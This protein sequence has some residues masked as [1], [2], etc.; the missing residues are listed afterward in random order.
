MCHVGRTTSNKQRVQAV[1][2]DVISYEHRGYTSNYRQYL[3]SL[4]KPIMHLPTNSAFRFSLSSLP[5]PSEDHNSM[6][7]MNPFRFSSFSY[8]PSPS[9]LIVQATQPLSPHTPPINA[10]R[11]W[12][13]PATS[14]TGK[15]CQQE[16]GEPGSRVSTSCLA[17]PAFLRLR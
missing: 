11:R 8:L 15:F 3:T 17:N 7:A 13:P 14:S 10:L 6:T 5:S 2:C 16:T 4:P 9:S 1:L 12:T